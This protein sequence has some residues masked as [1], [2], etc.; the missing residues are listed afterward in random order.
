MDERLINKEEHI[1]KADPY[2]KT[3][4]FQDK[5]K[6]A[7]FTILTT[8]HKDYYHLQN[9]SIKMASSVIARTQ[10]YLESCCDVVGWF[11][12]N[13]NDTKDKKIYTLMGDIYNE[14]ISDAIYLEMTRIEKEHYTK[15]KFYNLL[16][17]NI[18]FRRYYRE[19]YNIDKNVIMEWTKNIT[20]EL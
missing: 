10:Q 2:Y 20:N 18:F 6:C 4:E 12:E 9:S 1:Y 15:T 7:L 5:Y 3:L 8:Y 16:R 13:Y 17:T 14:F 11:K 19:S